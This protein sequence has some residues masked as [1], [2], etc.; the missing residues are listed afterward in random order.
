MDT[1]S[2]LKNHNKNDYMKCEWLNKINFKKYVLSHVF[3]F[4]DTF[5]YTQRKHL[6]LIKCFTVR[7]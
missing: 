3:I 2:T 5:I 4:F 7:P 6:H 1:K